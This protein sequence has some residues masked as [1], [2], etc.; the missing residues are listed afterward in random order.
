MSKRIAILAWGSLTWD[1]DPKFDAFNSQ[2]LEWKDDGPQLPLEFSRISE[3]RSNSLTLVIDPENG[4]RCQVAF[5]LSE[6]QTIEDTIKDLADRESITDLTLI[7][8]V[9]TSPVALPN[10]R[11]I[12]F[13][14]IHEWARSHGLDG[15]VWTA[16]SSNFQSKTG[17]SFNVANA[18]AYVGTLKGEGRLKAREYVERAPKFIETPAREPLRVELRKGS[19]VADGQGERPEARQVSDEPPNAIENES[20]ARGKGSAE[21]GGGITLNEYQDRYFPIYEAYGNTVR[22]IIE[23]ALQA[24]DSLPRPQS[25]QSRAKTP[26]S[27][28]RR[29]TEA[30]KL[31]TSSLDRERRDLAGVRLIFYTNNDV[32]RFLASPLVHENF[33]IEEES[34]KI[35]HPTPDKQESRYR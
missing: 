2:R 15:V 9:W 29:L 28:R 13:G 18:V 25:I 14:T 32:E 5:A 11:S 16:L 4:T 31:D 10:D 27:V 6:R 7:G 23:Q 12:E 21:D 19:E 35:H 24:A 17:M 22:F 30:G 8:S 3:T 34:T 26:E 20:A 33:E 1:D